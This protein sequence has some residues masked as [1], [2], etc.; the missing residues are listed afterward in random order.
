[1]RKKMKNRIAISVQENLEEP[2]W[3]SNVEPFVEK[4][5]EKLNFQN[6]E[7]SILFCDN[8]YIQ[9]LNKNYREID[10]S[11]DVLSFENDFVYTD[12]EGQ[13]RAVG[14]IA[15]SVEMVPENAAYFSTTENAELKRLLVHGILHL[16]GMDHGEEHIENGKVPE[17]EMLVLQE[18][19]LR[20]FEDEIIIKKI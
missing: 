19:I 7:I 2:S 10:N 14:D 6:E 20:D 8:S 5:L 9:E 15:I 13:W 3:L 12:D 18:N 4:I 11:T 16:N 17:C 1:M